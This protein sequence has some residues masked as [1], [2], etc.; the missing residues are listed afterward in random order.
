MNNAYSMLFAFYFIDFHKW[1]MLCAH[2]GSV[3]ETQRERK[4]E[5]VYNFSEINCIMHYWKAAGSNCYCCDDNG[6][7]TQTNICRGRRGVCAMRTN[8]MRVRDKFLNQ[9][10]QYN[11]CWKGVCVCVGSVA[12]VVKWNEERS[13]KGQCE[14]DCEY[15]CDNECDCEYDCVCEWEWG[16][17]NSEWELRVSF[18]VHTRRADKRAENTF[19]N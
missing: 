2:T 17:D 18:M 13:R 4:R 10:K 15:E 11:W 3:R 5:G 7:T 16:V 9:L 12:F 1:F 19:F 14:C 8:M 6:K